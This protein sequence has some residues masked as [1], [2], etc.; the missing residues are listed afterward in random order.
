MPKDAPSSKPV[1]ADARFQAMELELQ[2]LK[3]FSELSSDW[4]WEQDADLRFT[5]FFGVST[6]KLRRS[7]GDFLGKRRWDMPISGVSAD[8]LAQHIATCEDRAP[9]RNFEY[10]VPGDDGV[11]QYYSISGTPVFNTQ[12]EFIGYHG[13]GRNTTE[14][15]MAERA[16]HLHLEK[17]QLAHA[18]LQRAMAQLVESEKLAALGALVAGISHELN[19]PIGVGLTAASALAYKATLFSDSAAAGISRLALDAFVRDTQTGADLLVRN[20]GRAA[21]LVNRFKQVAV[22]QSSSQR[23]AFEVQEVVTEI[24]LTLGPS[25]RQSDC[26]VAT[27]ISPGLRLD[28]YPG[29]LGQVLTHL[30]TNA[31][32]H[33]YAQGRGST[34]VF[35]GKDHDTAHVRLEVRDTGCGITPEN[36]KR[37][38]EPF[39]TTR[40]GQGGSGLGLYIVHN[41][42]TG[43]LGGQIALQ[44]APG[45]G[46][47]IVLILP[48]VAPG[49]NTTAA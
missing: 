47:A 3:D 29:P 11:L 22:D 25:F 33:A 18:E 8:A 26:A 41:I 39:F 15:H 44:S 9:F 38:F 1:D 31:M 12:N 19:T 16:E 5:R 48:R 21:D 13:V 24:V 34:I 36:Q 35:E 6:E 45:Q 14:L 27:H 17:L 42:V 37:V 23:R 20:L 32:T 49:T 4:F 46:T 7:Q 28:S 43:V 2:R 10:E 40:L 30:L